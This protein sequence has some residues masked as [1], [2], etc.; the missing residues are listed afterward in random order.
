MDKIDKEIQNILLKIKFINDDGFIK[1]I[2]KDLLKDDF[3]IKWKL[4]LI[5]VFKTSK[6][7]LIILISRCQN[8]HTPQ[9]LFFNFWKKNFNFFFLDF[10]VDFC[11]RVNQLK[12]KV[13]WYKNE[14]IKNCQK[15]TIFFFIVFSY[16]FNK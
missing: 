2:N 11:Q 10:F 13:F 15:K 8:G 7:A 9:N 16:I 5:N 4:L 1:D 6:M 3:N 14:K 12:I